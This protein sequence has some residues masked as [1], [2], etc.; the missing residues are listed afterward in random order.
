MHHYLKKAFTLSPHVTVKKVV[1]QAV[2][3]I[4]NSGAR[5]LDL[6][7]PTFCSMW[8]F[9][10]KL[11]CCLK[12]NSVEVPALH[13]EQCAALTRYF[14]A[15][16]FDLLGSGWV[17]VYHGMNCRGLEGNRYD[18]GESVQVDAEG[19]WLAGRIN[20]SNLAESQQIWK[21]VDLDYTP[22][23]WLIDFKSGYRWAEK[24]WY[25]DIKYG[26]KPGVDVKVPWEL[27]RMQHLPQLAWAFALAREGA[28][29]FSPAEDYAREF[30]NQILDFIATNPPRY[31]VNW[32]CTMD[33]G[34]RVANWLISYDLFQSFGAEFDI[35]FDKVLA[36][37]VYEHG[38]HCIEHLEY[39]SK[40]RSNHYLS[41][42]A[43][44]LFAAAYLAE[45]P[46]TDRWL[47]FALQELVS[48]MEHEFH[49]DGSNFEAS[50][51]YHRLSTEIMLYCAVLCLRLAPKR[52]EKLM[53]DVDI[54]EHSVTPPLRPYSMQHY[55][56]DT[57]DIFPAW[58][59]ERLERATEFTLHITAPNG[60][61]PQFG[62]NDSG[63]FLKFWPSCHLITDQDAVTRY[64][65]LAG[66]AGLPTGE[67]YP[68][69]AIL[70]H[71][72]LVQV[73]SVLFDRDDMKR[74]RPGTPEKALVHSL[75]VDTTVRSFRAGQK[76]APEQSL[77]TWAYPDFGLYILRSPRIYLAIRCGSIGQCGIGGHAHN[78]QLSFVLYLDDVPVFIDPG[79]YLYTPAPDQRNLFR[80][81]ERHNTVAMPGTE[82]HRWESGQRG[83]FFLKDK[84]VAVCEA[85]ESAGNRVLFR[86]RL[87]G[88]GGR[89][90]DHL[91]EIRIDLEL[92]AIEIHD[93]MYGGEDCGTASLI[94]P[95]PIRPIGEHLMQVGPVCLE[96]SSSEFEICTITCSPKYGMVTPATRILFRFHGSNTTR[97][98]I[99]GDC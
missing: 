57:A 28:V 33:V 24:T 16:Q 5:K 64:S 69:E 39:S 10:L 83:L 18:V 43:G 1:V 50:T 41:D 97:L 89:S 87:E 53:K 11:Q 79:T 22:I 60:E 94:T 65:N 29:R 92:G 26:Q 86:G 78:D 54:S 40:F 14:V 67:T 19:K 70:D 34:I 98:R 84:G 7:H 73:A 45:T 68:D 55:R 37:S 49:R 46:E 62:D 99:Q 56:L 42:I 77:Q 36:R 21:L 48:E 8:P 32:C 20:S 85:W 88:Y 93:K 76:V 74:F 35:D 66:Y 23:D 58:F 31:G 81:T 13:A 91:R 71:S 72:H 47:A 4:R 95:Q 9:T 96:N 51:S 25:K 6:K 27:A 63:R 12:L 30:R 2:K 44:L 90:V 15:H 61:I 82:Q 59:W 17:R 3:T 80:S 38:R 52:R 75:L